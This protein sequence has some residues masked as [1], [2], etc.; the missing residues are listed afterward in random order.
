MRIPIF[1]DIRKSGQTR[2][3]NEA[4]VSISID[5]RYQ[6]LDRDSQVQSYHQ[7]FKSKENNHKTNKQKPQNVLKV[8]TAA[9]VK[10]LT[11]MYDK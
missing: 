2:C 4:G 6:P 7:N 9:I 5:S 1:F 10:I 8:S 11:Q 3:Q